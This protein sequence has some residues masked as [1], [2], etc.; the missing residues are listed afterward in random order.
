VTDPFPLN[1]FGNVVRNA[2]HPGSTSKFPLFGPDSGN[3]VIDLSNTYFKLGDNLI[4]GMKLAELLGLATGPTLETEVDALAKRLAECQSYGDFFAVLDNS[5]LSKDTA[6]IIG[7]KMMDGKLFVNDLRA[8]RGLP[9][10]DEDRN[11]SL[12]VSM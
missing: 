7:R 4:S 2:G 8:A 1:Q 12:A 3:G 9:P 11:K 5:F 6:R 10:L